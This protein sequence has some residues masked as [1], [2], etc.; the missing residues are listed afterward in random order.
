MHH[1]ANWHQHRICLQAARDKHDALVRE[2]RDLLDRP[3]VREFLAY[4]PHPND[5]FASKGRTLADH[6]DYLIA[7]SSKTNLEKIARK[8]RGIA[9]LAA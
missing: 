9:A 5:Y 6:Y 4:E 7:R 8:L 3:G 1:S 2:C